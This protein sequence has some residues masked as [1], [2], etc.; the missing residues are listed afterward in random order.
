MKM[1]DIETRAD[2]EFL[3]NEFYKT[4]IADEQIGHHFDG[5]NLSEHLPVIADFWEKI[6]FGKPVYFGNPLQVHQKLNEKSPLSLA[7]F[8]RWTEIFARAVE[9]HFAGERADAAK[10]RARMIA[11]SLNQNINRNK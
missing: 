6:L 7:D 1:K 11:H 9:R 4:A 2:V 10:L 5:L 8:R 3:L